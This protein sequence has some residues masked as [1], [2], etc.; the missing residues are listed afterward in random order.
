MANGHGQ[1][2]IF[3]CYENCY[4][5]H[6]LSIFTQKTLE[7]F[8]VYT[9]KLIDVYMDSFKKVD[10]NLYCIRCV[11]IWLGWLQNGLRK[12]WDR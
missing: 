9:T 2:V 1:C 4:S 8:I 6:M 3:L 11:E 12:P 5:V 7:L 10:L